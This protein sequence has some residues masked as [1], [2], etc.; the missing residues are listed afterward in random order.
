MNEDCKILWV[1][2]ETML[3]EL[4]CELLGGE[5]YQCVQARNGVDAQE[6]L[7]EDT[8]SVLIL[9]FQMPE[10]NGDELLFWLR[11]KEIHTPVVFVTGKQ[12]RKASEELALKDCCTSVLI[13]PFAIE[14]LIEEIDRARQRKHEFQCSGRIVPNEKADFRSTFPHQHLSHI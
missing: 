1:E 5:G 13:K 10:M 12:E 14:A 9:D 8:F 4:M 3:R 7:N 2:D 6:K 11:Q